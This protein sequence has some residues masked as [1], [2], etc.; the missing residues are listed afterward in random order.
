MNINFS[1]QFKY[2][3]KVILITI[4]VFNTI[5]LIT[6]GISALR[7]LPV[8]Y[9]LEDPSSL[10]GYDQ[11]IGFLT[12]IGVVV[13]AIGI[14]AVL[15]SASVKNGNLEPEERQVLNALIFLAGV[16]L[17][18]LLDDLFLLHERVFT[19]WF[20]AGERRIFLA[21]GLIFLLL[22]YV[23]RKGLLSGPIIFL[24][25]SM[26]LFGVSIASDVLTDKVSLSSGLTSSMK[27]LEEAGKLGGYLF[28][29]AFI[30]MKARGLLTGE[31]D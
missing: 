31:A 9:L 20:Q 21:Y 23:Y 13:L 30:L 3:G 24:I 25:I 22:A 7:G 27:M 17:F 4:L 6:W 14:G 10:L 19:S 11:F 16:S 26:L 1:K 28:W 5:L 2:Y 15:L 18:L 12:P 29:T 8:E